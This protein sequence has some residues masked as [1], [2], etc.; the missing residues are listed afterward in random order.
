MSNINNN[1]LVAF[2]DINDKYAWANYGQFKLIMMKKNG[3]VNAT[4]MCDEGGKS[5]FN[6]K[7]NSQS[8]EISKAVAEDISDLHNRS[9][10]EDLFVIIST[11]S[12]HEAYLRGTYVHPDLLL[13][14]ACYV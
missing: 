5:F 12:K 9:S 13:H 11:G 10:E 2:E 8:K 3:Y 1:H 6:W 4:K 14:I 7:R